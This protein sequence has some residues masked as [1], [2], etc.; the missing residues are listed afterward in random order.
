MK[1]LKLILLVTTV[2]QFNIESSAQSSKKELQEIY[3]GALNLLDE[4]QFA[5]SLKNERDYDR[6]ESLFIN[7]KVKVFND[8]MPENSLNEKVESGQYLRLW[9][10]HY[11]DKKLL[12]IY[13]EPYEMGSVFFYDNTNKTGY[14]NIDVYKI[15]SGETDEGVNYVDTFDINVKV[16]FNLTSDIFKIAD[17]NANRSYGSYCVLELDFND[18][19]Q[20]SNSIIIERDELEISALDT[21]VCPDKFYVLKDIKESTK[22]KV[23]AKNETLIPTYAIAPSDSR[24]PIIFRKPKWYVEFDFGINPF[25]KGP[26]VFRGDSMNINSVNELSYNIGFNI[27][28]AILPSQNVYIKTGLLFNHLNYTTQLDEHL[29]KNKSIDSDAFPYLRTNK[30]GKISENVELQFLKIPI[31]IQKKFNIKESKMYILTELGAVWNLSLNS[32]YKSNAEGSYSGFYET[33]FEIN[34][35]E[36][37]VYNFGDFD[38]KDGDVLKVESTSLSYYGAIGIGRKLNRRFSMVFMGAYSQGTSNLFKEDYQGLSDN[39]SELKS[40]TNVSNNFTLQ[41]IYLSLKLNY[42]F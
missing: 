38:L 29:Y 18:I 7:L 4:Y 14:I 6:F 12:N 17:I 31:L 26:V 1:Y 23:S 36:N 8:I 35:A 20:E 42:S 28:Y 25:K 10:R 37:G 40:I 15:C 24:K 13:M 9:E 30:V 32:K 34:L 19:P 39:Y 41:E 11:L 5:F 3:K 16:D 27:G 33:L 2:F 22:I 21:V